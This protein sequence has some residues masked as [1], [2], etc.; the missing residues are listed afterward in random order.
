MYAQIIDDTKGVTLAAASDKS[1]SVV[2]EKIAKLA[3]A[4]KITHIVF[5]RGS[6]AYHGKIKQ[7]AEAARAANLKF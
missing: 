7:L 5:D 4:A 1:A 6:Y 3:I 2:G